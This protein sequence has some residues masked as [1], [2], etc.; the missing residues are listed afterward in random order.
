[1]NP[2]YYRNFL[3][4]Y[5]FEREMTMWAYY[6]A[7]K[8]LNTER[9]RW[10]AEIVKRRMPGLHIRDPD[11]SRFTDEART[12]CRIYNQ[13]FDTGWGHV[14]ITEAEFLYMANAMRPFLDPG[15]VF[16]LEHDGCPVG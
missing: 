9:L 7:W 13:A 4:R 10:G 5:G 12:M 3:V 6:G 15:I 11:M 2:A 14:P 16:F 1:Y 8:H